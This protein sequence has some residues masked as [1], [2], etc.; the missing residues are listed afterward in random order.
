MFSLVSDLINLALRL[1][2]GIEL[3]SHVG[4][5]NLKGGAS[6]NQSNQ[7]NQPKGMPAGKPAAA[8]AGKPQAVPP[9]KPMGK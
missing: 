2:M 6:V 9:K 4:L 3:V 8:P 1:R 7:K 5:P